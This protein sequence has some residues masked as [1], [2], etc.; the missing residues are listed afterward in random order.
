MAKARKVRFSFKRGGKSR[1][2]AGARRPKIKRGGI[3]A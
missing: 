1:D 3:R 2:L